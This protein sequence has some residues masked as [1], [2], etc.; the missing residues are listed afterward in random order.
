MEF[1]DNTNLDSQ[2][3]LSEAACDDSFV[4]FPDYNVM[5]LP[6]PFTGPKQGAR[7]RGQYQ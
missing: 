2:L 1:L 7:A 3:I 6:F 5:L 4:I